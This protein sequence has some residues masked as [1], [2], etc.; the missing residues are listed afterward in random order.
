MM[1][2]AG[3]PPGPHDRVLKL[4]DGR[5]LGYAE[6]GD[7]AGG[8]LFFFHGCRGSRFSGAF[9]DAAAKERGVR[10]VALERPGFGLSDFQLGRSIAAWPADVLEAAQHLGCERFAVLG[11]GAGGPYA[12]ACAAM[13]GEQLSAVSAVSSVGLPGSAPPGRLRSNVEAALTSLLARRAPGLYVRRLARNASA[14]DRATLS[15]PA[16]RATLLKSVRE[17][18]RHGSRGVVDDAAL[19]ARPWGVDFAAISTPV[20]LWHAG[21]DQTVPVSAARTLAGAIPGCGATF[22]PGGGHFWLLD[23]GGGVLDALFPGKQ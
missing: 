23:H 13:L 15:R 6:F 5:L 16:E 1:R 4:P 11:F 17:A 14:A 2:H 7:P 12:L 19:L 10:V 18:F 20:S 8:T 22:V 21:D 9:L 3:K